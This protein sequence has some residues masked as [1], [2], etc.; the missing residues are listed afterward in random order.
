MKLVY[1][2]NVFLFLILIQSPAAA[3]YF[4]NKES[5]PALGTI[6][7]VD[8]CYVDGRQDDIKAAMDAVWRRVDEIHARLNPFSKTSDVSL[9]NASHG[10]PTRVHDDVYRLLKLSQRGYETTNGVFDVTIGPLMEL[11][12]NAEKNRRLPDQQEIADVKR[13]VDAS[14][15]ILSSYSFVQ[16]PENMKLDVSGAAQGFA[17]DEIKDVLT[18]HGFHNFLVDTGG[19]IYAAGVNCQEK[20]WKVGIKNPLNKEE[21]F[22]AVELHDA[23]LS[24]SG[25]YERNFVIN[26]E[27]RSKII[28]P[29]TGYPERGVASATVIAPTAVEADILSTTV[30]AL[31]PL[32]G[33]KL[34]NSFGDNYA[35]LI[36]STSQSGIL[37]YH[38]SPEYENHRSSI[39]KEWP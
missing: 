11:W 5:R 35:A 18:A 2:A 29:K 17:A 3:Q 34:I 28:Q 15:I 6:V 4:E 39:S 25:N 1:L 38:S 23:A 27:Q 19:E 8:V 37:Q 24:T 36:L 13:H 32:Q 12:A 30:C 31:G 26:G 21:L 10:R 9:I 14:K 20:P 16:L 7:S 33:L 22:D